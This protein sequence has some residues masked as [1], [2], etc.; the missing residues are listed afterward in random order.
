MSSSPTHL[1]AEWMTST[2]LASVGSSL[3]EGST[4][5]KR[6]PLGS[7]PVIRE[8]LPEMFPVLFIPFLAHLE[9]D[10]GKVD[11]G[12]EGDAGRED[13]G[14]DHVAEV[15]RA[16]EARE[17]ALPRAVDAADAIRLADDVIPLDLQR[18][19]VKVTKGQG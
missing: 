3:F 5:W 17:T 13:G 19:K 7:R 10:A 11:G 1:P 2:N 6:G 18:S 15:L 4:V 8:A 14:D 9:R 16:L 12:E